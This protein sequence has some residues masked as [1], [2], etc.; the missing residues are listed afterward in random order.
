MILAIDVKY[1]DKE[2]TAKA[3]GVLFNW[4]D[5]E[6]SKIIVKEVHN[7]HEYIS[8][9]FYK[10]E[11]PCILEILKAAINIDDIDTVI[12]DGHVYI[13]NEMDYGLGAHL[14]S[15]LNGRIPVIGVAKRTFKTN[16]NTVAKLYRG[17]SKTPLYVSSIGMDLKEAVKRIQQMH[18]SYR[19]PTILK[20][21]DRITKEKI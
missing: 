7:I 16:M 19:L 2:A 4:L 11:L 21:V 13:S 9:Q 8:G 1:Y 15:S 12:V 10:R 6:P 17:E 5:K 14:W 18:G 3:I 20:E